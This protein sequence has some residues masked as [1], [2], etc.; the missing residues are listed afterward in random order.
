MWGL[1]HQFLTLLRQNYRTFHGIEWTTGYT[2]H[3][4]WMGYRRAL[5]LLSLSRSRIASI[6]PTCLALPFYLPRNLFCSHRDLL[7]C[8]LVSAPLLIV[9]RPLVI[10]LGN[11]LLLGI[12]TLGILTLFTHL[13]SGQ[14]S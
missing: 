3:L 10:M 13:P 4:W 5:R 9:E 1:C 8:N 14:K 2:S 12:K 11:M 6:I 7:Q